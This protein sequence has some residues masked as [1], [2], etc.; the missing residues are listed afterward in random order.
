[1][2]VTPYR[3]ASD[4]IHNVLNELGFHRVRAL[5]DAD[6]ALGRLCERERYGL[7]I[8]DWA[9]EPRGGLGLLQAIRATESLKDMPVMLMAAAPS[10]EMVISA[11]DAGAASFLVKPFSIDMLKRKLGTV[12][13]V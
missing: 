13:R 12:L 7:V 11:K 4:L 10:R 3:E 1:M 9:I 8:V 5:S 6:A 2:I